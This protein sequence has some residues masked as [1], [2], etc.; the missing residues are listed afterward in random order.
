MIHGLPEIAAYFIGAVAGG[1]VSMAVI[2]QD[3]SKARFKEIVQ[4]FINLIILAIVLLF[5][6]GLVEVIMISFFA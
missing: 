1:I 5:F 3:F 6:A 4:D 2:K